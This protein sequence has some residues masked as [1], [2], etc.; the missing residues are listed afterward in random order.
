MI[1]RN[2]RSG[3]LGLVVTIALAVL[4]LAA[5]SAGASTKPYSV[6]LSPAAV[7]SGDRA[8]VAATFTNKARQ[9]LGSANLT[10]PAGYQVVSAELAT[11]A[12]ATATATV[13]G[14]TVQLRNLALAPK[15]SLGV[16]VTV[17]VPCSA[18]TSTWSVVAKQANDFNGDPG[19]DFTLLAKES[20]LTTTAQGGCGVRF[21]TQPQSTQLGQAITGPDGSPVKVALVDGAGA[22][23]SRVSAPVAIATGA[24]SPA[25]TLTGT[26]TRDAVDGVASFDD[27]AITNV[28]GRYTLTASSGG[29][30]TT[31]DPFDVD[32]S[33][34]TCADN[35]DCTGTIVR[36]GVTAAG[37]P[38]RFGIKATAIDN[39]NLAT[40]GGT[41][42]LSLYDTSLFGCEGYTPPV[43]DTAQVDGLKREYKVELTTNIGSR[44]DMCFAAPYSFTTK[45]LTPLKTGTIGGKEVFIGLLPNCV[46][47]TT[48][49]VLPPPCIEFFESTENTIVAR[50][51]AKDPDPYSR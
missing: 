46:D 44:S 12:P 10:A 39:P 3:P 4:A 23:R 38:Y 49:L 50:W 42:T 26:T 28:P 34:V 15:Q 32:Q 9:E 16:R 7:A 21:E 30:T 1:A 20:S 8:A 6:V 51:P 40:D 11:G 33:T 48:G 47:I 31:S 5:V 36:N 18:G 35:V 24:G 25:G 29:S 17:D 27:L 41:M 14:A 2:A 13:S 45:P 22:V 37:E 19:N 43:A